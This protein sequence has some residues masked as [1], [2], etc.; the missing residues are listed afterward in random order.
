M[1]SFAKFDPRAFLE[2]DQRANAGLARAAQDA[3]QPADNAKT[4]AALAT[5]AASPPKMK[6]RMLSTLLQQRSII[7]TEKI[8]NPSPALLKLL[9][10]L[11]LIHPSSQQMTHYGARR[12][13][14]VPP[15]SSTTAALRERGRKR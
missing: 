12:R 8:V 1:A 13:K 2:S 7:I 11:K 4:L 10:L 14:S 6:I 15:S 9:K 3:P 5:L